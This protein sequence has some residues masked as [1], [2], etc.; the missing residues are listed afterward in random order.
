M[1]TVADGFLAY[2]EGFQS[3]LRPDPALWIDE[4]ADAYQRIPQG[5][6]A[7]HGKYHTAR[8]PFAREVMR[9]L[10][11][12]HPAKRVAVKG[13]SQLLK[14]QVGLNF[15]GAC[16]HQAPSN[17]LVLLPTDKI[18]KRVSSRI[19]K[20]IREVPELRERVAKPRARDSKNTSDTKEFN[21]GTLYITT[22]GS[23]SNL[24]EVP[25]RYLYGDEIDRWEKSVDKEG[26][27]IDLAEN[28][29][30]TYGRNF[31]AYY[32]SSPTFLGDSAIDALFEQGDQR[33]YHVPCPHCG[34]THT[35][36]LEAL[37]T[38]EHGNVSAIH[39]NQLVGN[40]NVSDAWLECPAC[41]GEIR[42]E[43]K[44]TMLAAGQWVA[45]AQGDGETVSF[46]ISAFYA[47]VGWISLLGLAKQYVKAKAKL[48]RGDNE[49]MRVFYNT[50]L[51]LVYDEIS[52]RVTADQL[53]ALKELFRLGVA[54]LGVAVL[55]AAVD[56]Q[57]NRLEVAIYGW[58]Y[59]LE[60]W[61]VNK[62]VISGDPAEKSTWDELDELLRTPIPNA[63]GL[64]MVIRAVGIDTGGHHTQEVYDYCRAHKKRWILG[65]EQRIL[66]IKG[67]SRPGRPILSSRP[68]LVDINIRGSV[69]KFGGELWL[70]GT[71]TAK[72]WLYNRMQLTSPGPGAIHYAQDL[73]DEFFD[74]IT[75]E[76]KKP[77]YVKGF[78]RV[79]W[80][81]E[82]G[83]RNEDGDLAVYNLAMAHFLELNRKPETWWK[84]K[85]AE[86][87]PPTGDLFG[88]SLT[89]T[90][91]VHPRPE[92]Q[93]PA[94]APAPAA[95]VPA[96]ATTPD[97]PA[98]P[99]EPL[100]PPK[101]L[102]PAPAEKHPPPRIQPRPDNP[103]VYHDDPWMHV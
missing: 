93:S 76:K 37:R 13:A 92:V 27:P 45:H 35:L 61:T 91:G 80:V 98:A 23:A 39:E 84:N 28:R 99:V 7:E 58:G 53:R 49:S 19:E 94:P 87:N 21:G 11:P 59:G 81:K 64:P 31:K 79:E 63:A 62:H 103:V 74:Q 22:A 83:A 15:I 50:R 97:T 68:S 12:L 101:P 9:C 96:Q 29:G 10:S 72:D 44:T 34:H 3:G 16:I 18:A 4:W 88:A 5:A 33:H 38:R 85:L 40:E 55:T 75:A 42:N 102:S 46:T 17:I 90:L 69:E 47:P 77:R 41:H 51:A 14:T 65:Q 66:A 78:L 24:A 1:N 57:G 8:T 32:S 20:T 54:P 60:R 56:V 2:L 67:A 43:H 95:P 71:D 89:G 48:A 82:A 100:P 6:G 36:E 86:L 73:P 30:N 70:I 25:V 26:N 52:E